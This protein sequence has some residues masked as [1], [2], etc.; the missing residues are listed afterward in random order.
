MVTSPFAWEEARRNLERKRPHLLEGLES[1]RAAAGISKMIA[2]IEPVDLAE[3]DQ[4]ILGGAVGSACTHLWTS[5]RLHFGD[6]YA[7]T[8]Q[9]VCVVSSIQIA[10]LLESDTAGDKSPKAPVRPTPSSYGVHGGEAVG[11]Y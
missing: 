2:A 3:K 4:P 9:G 6:L 1:L 7:R 11:T 5:D 8:V 10:D